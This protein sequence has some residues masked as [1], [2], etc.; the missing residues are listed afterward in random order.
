MI[1]ACSPFGQAR[2]EARSLPH[3]DPPGQARQ[4]VDDRGRRFV[5]P[6]LSHAPPRGPGVLPGAR[7]RFEN[8]VAPVN[9]FFTAS[10]CGKDRMPACSGGAKRAHPERGAGIKTLNIGAAMTGR[11]GVLSIRSSNAIWSSPRGPGLAASCILYPEHHSSSRSFSRSTPWRQGQT[12]QL[13][14]RP[15]GTALPGARWAK[16]GNHWTTA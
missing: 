3:P 11:R 1:P 6:S 9:P 8:A 2:T 4:G 12:C 7:V 15:T 16:R 5:A 14:Y 10:I 13:I